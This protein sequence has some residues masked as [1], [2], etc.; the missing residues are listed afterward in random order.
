M[1][2]NSPKIPKYFSEIVKLW[3]EGYRNNK[4]EFESK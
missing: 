2:F 4:Q 3:E 1:H